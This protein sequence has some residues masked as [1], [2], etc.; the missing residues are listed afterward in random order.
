MVVRTVM[1]DDA[2]DIQ[3]VWVF[4]GRRATFPSGVFSSR[5]SA[6]AWIAKHSLKGTLT[7]YPLNVGAYEHAIE[8]EWFTP[9]SRV[10]KERVRGRFTSPVRSIITTRTMPMKKSEE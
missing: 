6:D 7:K 4:N 1:Q 3:Y 10:K 8:M 5:E 2:D 9:Q